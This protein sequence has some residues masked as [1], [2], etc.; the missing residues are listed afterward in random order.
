MSNPQQ[1]VSAADKFWRWIGLLLLIGLVGWVLS[2]LGIIDDTSSGGSP[3]RSASSCEQSWDRY[4]SD[5]RPNNLSQ[6]TYV[7]ECEVTR[8]AVAEARRRQGQ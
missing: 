4:V 5:G 3:T 2:A 6:A 8:A 7:S 1:P